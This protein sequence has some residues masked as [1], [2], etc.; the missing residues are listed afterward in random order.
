[1]KILV[2]LKQVPSPENSFSFVAVSP[3]YQ[4]SGLSYKINSYDEYALEQ[5]LSIQ[6][7]IP[8]TNI[9]I[10]SLGPD[11]V[12]STI[13][14]GLE[15]GAAKGI[16]L[17]DPLVAERDAY[18]VAAIIADWACQEN[19]DLI[20]TGIMAED[21]QRGQ[22]GPF[23]AGIL[24][25]PYSTAVVQLRLNTD[26]T[27]VNIERERENGYFET[28]ELPLPALLTIQSS[29]Q[30]PRYPS[31]SNKLRA[32]KQ[33]IL[34]LPSMEGREIPKTAERLKYDSPDN[35]GS[36]VYLS[37]SLEEKADALLDI[38]TKKQLS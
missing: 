7:T 36:A 5:A 35:I 26:D 30:T 28:I 33:T 14:R 37:G 15:M 24:K 20:L 11:R 9:T 10:V 1:M 38:F 3:G 12:L 16:H 6:D 4:E 2:C 21:D 19:F 29:P 17:A 25:I 31:L 18:A 27:K 32:R 13:K 23:L 8:D 34:T 22:T